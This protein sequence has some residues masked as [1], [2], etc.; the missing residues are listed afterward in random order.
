MSSDVTI[1]LK[2]VD[3]AS[4]VLNDTGNA[5]Q[6][7]GKNLLT[8]AKS[9]GAVTLAY[10][11]MDYLK[12][13][14]TDTVAYAE[15]VRDL[16]RA[17]GTNAEEA[18]K[19]LQIA[20]D[21][22]IEQTQLAMAFRY[23]I[24][25]GVDPSIDGLKELAKEY[26][27]IRDPIEKAQFA[28]DKFG[29]RGGLQMQKV[30]ELTTEQL[31]EMAQSAEDAGLVLSNEGV[32]AAR[33]Y[34]IAMD[35][36]GDAAEGLKIKIGTGLIPVVTD[37]AL[38]ANDLISLDAESWF[39][40]GADAAAKFINSLFYGKDRIDD[41]N[42]GLQR[43]AKED[44]IATAATDGL[45]ASVDNAGT[46]AKRSWGQFYA[47]SDAI[48]EG[49]DAADDSLSPLQKM[50][51]ILDTDVASP[52]AAF[53]DDLKWYQAGGGNINRAFELIKEGVISGEITPS[54][55]QTMLKGLFVAATDLQNELDMV[56]GEE[57]AQ[58]ISDT[59]GV[60]LEE[61]TEMI[62]G[63]DG[64]YGAMGALTSQ[65]WYVDIYYREHNKPPQLGGGTGGGG[66]GE[67]L[68]P[69]LVPGGAT[70][71]H[72]IVPSGYPND[73]YY[74]RATS[75]ERVDI[76]PRGQGGGSGNVIF[77]DIIINAIAGMD[78][79]ALANYTAQA[80]SKRVK[81]SMRSGAQYTG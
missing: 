19:L 40:D 50:F 3:Q 39:D 57:A 69:G 60:S 62:N 30:L 80:I 63:T 14:V 23:A 34:E 15:E 73:S 78:E 45:A 24:N 58:N 65:P 41:F 75:G 35:N 7:L 53:I 4:K 68:E 72:G 38:L 59:L 36:L 54:E 16:S 55:G 26:Q 37:F 51:E 77:G 70:G 33:E 81:H 46:Q 47:L 29:T 18:S 12:S 52:I 22:K 79:L 21:L 48:R 27:G 32:K 17:L 20:D 9:A 71:L 10:K 42:V 31:D 67:E 43:F 13:T 11:G 6:N 74:L 61:A 66:G 25:E 5:T 8:L 49:A 1:V 64:I 76:T 56:D 44:A 2:A 28:M